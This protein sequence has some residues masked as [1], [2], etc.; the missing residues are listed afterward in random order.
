MAKQRY[1]NTIFWRDEY[2]SRL[3]PSEKLLFLYLLTNPDTSI[4]G[5]YQLPIKIIAVDTGFDKEMVEKILARFERDD[6]VFYRDGWVIIKNF[7]KHQNINPSVT[8]GIERELKAVPADIRTL[9]SLPEPVPLN[10]TKPNLT[11]LNLTKPTIDEI[12]AYLNDNNITS[13]TA[14]H[15]WNYYESKGW[16]IGKTPMKSWKAA[17]NTWKANDKKN[18]APDKSPQDRLK[19]LEALES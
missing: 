2:V 11:K 3:D 14:E 12:Q 18:A 7:I 16:L 13:F 8:A 1:I 9:Y 15:F 5:I 6:K 19:E 4:C 10:L 17:V